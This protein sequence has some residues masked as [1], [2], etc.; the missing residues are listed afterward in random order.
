MDV[1]P[2]GVVEIRTQLQLQ[3][4]L[5]GEAYL[6][7]LRGVVERHPKAGAAPGSRGSARVIMP[8]T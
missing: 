5:D 7:S 8:V 1:G 2:A 6:P 3:D 4:P